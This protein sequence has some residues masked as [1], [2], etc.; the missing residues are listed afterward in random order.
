MSHELRER[1]AF[2][3]FVQPRRSGPCPRPRRETQDDA[4]RMNASLRALWPNNIVILA[5][6]RLP[7]APM[8]R[9]YADRSALAWC[10]MCSPMKL[11]MK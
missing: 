3:D 5:I 7:V 8:G 11:A 1:F 10:A 2:T 4:V 6:H 9:S